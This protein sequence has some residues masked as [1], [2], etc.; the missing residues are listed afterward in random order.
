MRGWIV[1]RRLAEY[2]EAARPD[3]RGILDEAMYGLLTVHVGLVL[4]GSTEPVCEWV[5]EG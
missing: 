3:G 1:Q 2:L 5:G 4:D